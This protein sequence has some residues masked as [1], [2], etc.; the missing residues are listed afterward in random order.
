MKNSLLM[1]IV[2]NPDTGCWIWNGQI[3][4]SGYGR[5]MLR[6][7][8]GGTSMQSAH[9][10]S[11]TA[12]VGEVPDGM[13]VRQTCRNRLCINPAHLELFRPAGKEQWACTGAAG[14]D[15]TSV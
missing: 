4:N 5:L 14:K 12:F 6:D 10:A 1:H 8:R 13:L 9:Q 11:Y 15:R 7:S 3:S 2:R